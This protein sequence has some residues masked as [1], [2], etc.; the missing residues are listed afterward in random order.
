M[1]GEPGFQ[2]RPGLLCLAHLAP[3]HHMRCSKRPGRLPA[4]IWASCHLANPAVRMPAR[5]HGRRRR[6]AAASARLG[7]LNLVRPPP[8]VHREFYDPLPANQSSWT[9][10]NHDCDAFH[11]FD[12]VQ[13]RRLFCALRLITTA[14]CRVLRAG[15]GSLGRE[16]KLCAHV[17]ACRTTSSPV[18][19]QGWR[20]MSSACWEPGGAAGGTVLG[21]VYATFV[22]P[23]RLLGCPDQAFLGHTMH[24][25][26]RWGGEAA[27]PLPSHPSPPPPFSPY[28]QAPPLLA[29][30]PASLRC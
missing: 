30:T 17:A 16:D 21:V 18:V 26:E 29:R 5:P 23:A 20:S 22:G 4:V 28:A 24:T 11:L 12:W 13:L 8:C 9:A 2:R 14:I 7:F 27:E 6:T 15:S 10:E 1:C 25:R 19:L 3:C